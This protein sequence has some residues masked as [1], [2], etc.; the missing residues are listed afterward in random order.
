MFPRRL[1]FDRS[2]NLLL[3]GTFFDANR[4]RVWTRRSSADA[5]WG[6]LVWLSEPVL[7]GVF[8]SF[9][10]DAGGNALAVWD[11]D[12]EPHIFASRA[13]AGGAWSR[14]EPIENG[15]GASDAVDARVAFD[16]SGNA[17]AVWA[18][19]PAN[20]GTNRHAAGSGWGTASTIASGATQTAGPDIAAAPGGRAIAVWSQADASGIFSIWAAVYEPAMGWGQPRLL[21][22]G[23]G[24]AAQSRVEFDPSGN[25][26]VVWAQNQTDRNSQARV[27][28]IG[29]AA[30]GWG[31]PQVIGDPG[32]NP[33]LV[34]DGNG[35][36]LV[37]FR[38]FAA[39]VS[40]IW[41]TRFE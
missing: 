34:L 30:A 8:A 24:Q 25:A 22:N 41:A 39:D 13:S 6:P 20:I 11:F 3:L 37:V 23:A 19:V 26:M 27:W 28:A 32:I 21:E 4:T 5:G 10:L 15:S 33:E 18:Q 16:G 1:A 2:G 35:D 31:E 9:D 38:R 17:I 14:P 12:R 29:Y 36:A 7:G 40:S